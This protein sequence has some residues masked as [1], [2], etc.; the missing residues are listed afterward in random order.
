M[1]EPVAGADIEAARKGNEVALAAI[2]TQSMPLIRRLARR[3]VRPGLDFEDAVQEGLIGLFAAIEKFTP[4][5]G[6]SFHTYSAVCVNNA[7]LSAYKAA[8]RKKHAPLNH[9]VPLTDLQSTPGP[10]EQT[11]AN[12]QVKQTLEKA[13]LTLS[14]LEKKVMQLRLQGRSGAEI[15]KLTDRPLKSVENA[16]RRARE[17]LRR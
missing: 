2:I 12:E 11:I 5:N 17:K 8:G 1:R 3:A 7:I 10:E 14:P 9:S 13:R 4:E 16:L 15:A 6:A